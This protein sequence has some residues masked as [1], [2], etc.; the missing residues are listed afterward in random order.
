MKKALPIICLLFAASVRADLF[1][2]PVETDPVAGPVISGVVDGTQP[3]DGIL[4]DR[5]I[6]SWSEI[7]LTYEDAVRLN[8]AVTITND[9]T[10]SGWITSGDLLTNNTIFLT[11]GEYLESPLQAD[12]VARFDV[13]ASS[14]G[15]GT[16]WSGSV[17]VGTNSVG[18]P[19]RGSNGLFRLVCGSTLPGQTPG[20]T[21]SSIQLTGYSDVSEAAEPKTVSGLR[22]IEDP[23][24]PDD[25]TPKRYV[26]EQAA[27]ARAYADNQISAYAADDGKTV[28]GKQIRLNSMWQATSYGNNWVLSAGEIAGDGSLTG[29]SNYFALAQNDYPLLTLSADSS[30]LHINDASFSSSGTN[31]TVTLYVATNGVTSAPYA[32]WTS[33]LIVGEWHRVDSYF[34][35]S[36]PAAVGSNY[37]M[38]FTAATGDVGYF[39]TMQPSGESSV[40]VGADKLVLNGNRITDVSR[41]VFTNGWSIQCTTNGLEFVQP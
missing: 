15:N 37:V 40:T 33:D 1:N 22:V 8:G 7:G 2:P 18:V 29:A 27:G 5:K 16:G 25:V 38:Q 24:L 36:W 20:L 21:V 12:G 10:W 30:G 26:D 14:A 31:T 28:R 34:T 32:E 13:S 39:R 4:L 11:E 3:L 19:Y 35:N 6:S 23:A 17:M 41:V 9:S